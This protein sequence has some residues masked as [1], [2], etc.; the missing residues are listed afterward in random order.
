MKS[1][2]LKRAEFKFFCIN[3]IP[4]QAFLTFLCKNGVRLT[5]FNTS[6]NHRE[7]KDAQA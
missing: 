3:N 4:E 7:I 2:K 6:K 5:D 1:K